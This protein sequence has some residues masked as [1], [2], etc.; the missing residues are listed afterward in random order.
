MH[1]CGLLANG[2]SVLISEEDGTSHGGEKNVMVRL[3]VLSW[4][5]HVSIAHP[6]FWLGAD[7][8]VPHDKFLNTL[9]KENMVLA[10]PCSAK[11]P[12]FGRYSCIT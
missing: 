12:L 11:L 9:K 6:A 4:N 10:E 1:M 2:I 5:K 3:S 8:S 7:A